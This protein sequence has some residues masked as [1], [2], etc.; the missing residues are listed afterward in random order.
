MERALLDWFQEVRDSDA[1][2]SSILLQCGLEACTIASIDYMDE[3]YLVF[4][5]SMVSSISRCVLEL[6]RV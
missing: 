2:R 4:L 1:R 3:V 5:P 6:E